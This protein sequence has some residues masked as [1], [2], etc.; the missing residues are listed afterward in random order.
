[1]QTYHFYMIGV[2]V[3]IFIF[4]IFNTISIKKKITKMQKDGDFD[5][6][7]IVAFK[8]YL[9]NG[10]ILKHYI[11]ANWKKIFS[12]KSYYFAITN[13]RAILV[14]VKNSFGLSG[15]KNKNSLEVAENLDKIKDVNIKDV[16]IVEQGNM[17]TTYYPGKEISFAVNDKKYLIKI[18]YGG[19]YRKNHDQELDTICNI[20]LKNT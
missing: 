7:I 1:M 15:T 5:K 9:K 18:K 16:N 4:V 12:Y 10:E 13:K 17:K 6:S 20:L 14:K 2:P 19:S 8:K 3:F 11:E